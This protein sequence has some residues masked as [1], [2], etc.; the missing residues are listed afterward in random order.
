MRLLSRLELPR[1][2]SIFFIRTVCP[3]IR[4]NCIWRK[5]C[6]IAGGGN[7][8]RD[9]RDAERLVKRPVSQELTLRLWKCNQPFPPTIAWAAA[10][11]EIGLRC[12]QKL[13]F[14]VIA[15]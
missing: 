14:G 13:R 7:A 3:H 5:H 6:R 11:R 8:Q 4:N 12:E 1:R 10:A 15:R 2:S 9:F